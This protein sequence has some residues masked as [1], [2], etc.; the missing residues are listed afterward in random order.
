MRNHS[1]FNFQG[2]ESDLRSAIT[3]SLSSFKRAGGSAQFWA[4]TDL[5]R[6]IE[7]SMKKSAQNLTFIGSTGCCNPKYPPGSGFKVTF[8]IQVQLAYKIRFKANLNVGYGRRFG[9]FA[10]TTSLHIVLLITVV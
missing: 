9:D 6:N 8:G 2:I 3:S 5:R 1:L 7:E 10:T 4:Q